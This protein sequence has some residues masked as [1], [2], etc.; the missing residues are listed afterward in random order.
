[1]CQ[2]QEDN[3]VGWMRNGRWTKD[4]DFGEGSSS[5]PGFPSQPEW[6]KSN[7]DFN[8]IQRGL[9][10][11]GFSKV[12]VEAIMGENWLRFFKDSFGPAS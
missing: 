9:Y 4:V 6:F 1:M 2:D 5:L 11:V 3:V 10:E 12:D 7:K 8:L